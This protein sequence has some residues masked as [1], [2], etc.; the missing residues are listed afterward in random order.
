MISQGY[1][2]FPRGVKDDAEVSRDEKLRRTLHAEQNAIL[3]AACDL[4][5]CTLY[6][7]HPPCARC[8]ALLIQ[9]GISRVVVKQADAAFRERW[10]EDIKSS[11]DMLFEAGVEYMEISEVDP[12]DQEVHGFKRGNLHVTVQHGANFFAIS[13]TERNGL[14]LD[15]YFIDAPVGTTVRKLMYFIETT[16]PSSIAFDLQCLVQ[17]EF[18]LERADVIGVHLGEEG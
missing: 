7:T 13:K 15:D 6:V 17:A 14:A 5:G 1:N 9:V 10:A 16:L 2:G 12:L 18:K 3:F 11:Q 4:G 8:T